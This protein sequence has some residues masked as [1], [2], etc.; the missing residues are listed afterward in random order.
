MVMD[1]NNNVGSKE[2]GNNSHHAEMMERQEPRR[3]PSMLIPEPET[4]DRYVKS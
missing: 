2:R 1:A 3:A 4:F